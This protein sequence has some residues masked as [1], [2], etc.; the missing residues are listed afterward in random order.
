MGPRLPP[1]VLVPRELPG[2]PDAR[3]HRALLAAGRRRPRP[4]LRARHDAAPGLRR[5][6]G[7]RRQRPQPVR[8]P[9]DRGQ[10]RAGDPGA[11]DDPAGPAPARLERELA[12]LARPGSAHLGRA[13]EPRIPGPDRRIGRFAA[14]RRRTRPARGR[15]RLPSADPR[16]AAVRP[17]DAPS[18]RSD[19]PLPGGGDDRDPPRQERLVP[20]GAD[21]Q[22]VLDGAALRPRLRRTDRVRLAGAR[23]LRRP[24]EEARSALPPAT[25]VDRRASPCS[26]THAMSRL[27]PARRCEHA[28]GPDRVRLVVTSPPYLRVVKYGY[29]NWLRT[30]FLGLR[31][32]GHRRDAR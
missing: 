28:A 19:R 23:R 18:R 12:R 20:L 4:V 32:A 31:C 14:R 2:R 5:G 25:A 10:G 27:V 29:Y 22:H 21:A 7:R 30:W 13:R 6:P 24:V 9:A 17:D 1:D 16:P 8:P 11:G 15:P 26:A 3:L